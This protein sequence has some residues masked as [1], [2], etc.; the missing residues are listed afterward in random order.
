MN[1]GIRWRL[2]ISGTK[3]AIAMVDL[4]EQVFSLLECSAEDLSWLDRLLVDENQR[5]SLVGIDPD[6]KP[7]FREFLENRGIPLE[8]LAGQSNK[9]PALTLKYLKPSEARTFDT[10]KLEKAKDLLYRMTPRLPLMVRDHG[11]FS[12]R[13][14]IMQVGLYMDSQTLGALHVLP[15]PGQSLSL[16]SVLKETKTPGGARLL[17]NWLVHPLIDAAAIEA[18]HELVDLFR[19][20]P[21]EAF[22]LQVKCLG[23]TSD[24]GRLVADIS[25]TPVFDSLDQAYHLY[26]S[27]KLVFTLYQ[28]LQRL[29]QREAL[30]TLVMH[31]LKEQLTKMGRFMECMEAN[32]DLS[33]RVFKPQVSPQFGSMLKKKS[34]VKGQ[35]EQVRSQMSQLLRTDVKL[36]E[37]PVMDQT[38]LCLRVPR[39]YQEAARGKKGVITLKVQKTEFLFST[40]ELQSLNDQ[41]IEVDEG[42]SQET[43]RL[44]QDLMEVVLTFIPVL[45]QLAYTLSMLD[46]LLAFAVVC[47]TNFVRPVLGDSLKIS[48]G[49]HLLVEKTVG[50]QYV[51]NDYQ[52]TPQESHLQLIMGPNMGGKSTYLRQLGT[53]ALLNQIGCFVPAQ[54]AELPVFTSIFTRVGA[55]DNAAAGYSTFMSEMVETNHILRQA[56]SK[57]L[58]L[59]DELGRGTS[60]ADGFGLAWA[61]AKELATTG[62]FTLFATHFHELVNLCQEYPGIQCKHVTALAEAH[63]VTFL[64]ALKNGPIDQSYGIHVAK[65]AG[66]PA[67]IIEKAQRIN[68]SF[69]Q[70]S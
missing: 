20:H 49:R 67:T 23:Q 56:S 39:T 68:A 30:E 8:I 41:L 52:M 31:P 50:S 9:D 45:R 18:R 2:Q 43:E 63:K 53:I 24:F 15:A 70:T 55:S 44:V 29:P 36:Q 13:E 27:V 33:T 40:G 32:V 19:Q 51:P 58:V 60:T 34:E 4:V 12:V 54:A 22:E 26:E 14:H 57:S 21:H 5:P 62:C 16:F 6:L 25:R 46:V 38:H 47:K 37:T 28:V 64:Y 11:Q 59:I 69:I 48:Q 65:M 35:M 10:L 66:F 17:K 42:L 7:K 61:I 3:T 1:A